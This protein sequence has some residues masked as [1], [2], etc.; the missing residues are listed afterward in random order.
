MNI[1]NSMKRKVISTSPTATVRE[2]AKLLL[3]NH[4]GTLP[5]VDGENQLIGLVRLRDLSNLAMPDFVKIL[6]Q[7]DFVLDFGA[8]EEKTLDPAILDMHISQIMTP[9][10]SVE[11]STGLLRAA[12]LLQNHQMSDLPVVDEDSRLVGIASYVDIGLALISH[13]DLK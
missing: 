9:P 3:A 2:A 1:G 4:I 11:E 7:F 5:V 6:D 12:A 8:V 13:W 10:V